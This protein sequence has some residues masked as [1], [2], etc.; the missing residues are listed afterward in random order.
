[1]DNYTWAKADDKDWH[2]L[3]EMDLNLTVLPDRDGV[4]LIFDQN[5]IVL[6]ILRGGIYFNL[7]DAMNDTRLIGYSSHVYATWIWKNEPDILKTYW[8]LVDH[9]QPIFN[10]DRPG[11]NDNQEQV[12]LPF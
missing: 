5:K 7:I 4:L 6:R 12:E 3:F 10:D 1:M 9:Y 11:E 2:H 8:Y